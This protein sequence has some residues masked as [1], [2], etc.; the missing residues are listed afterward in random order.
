MEQGE[1]PEDDAA[2]SREREAAQRFGDR[3]R[4]RRKELGIRQEDVAMAAGVSRRFVIDLEAG[5][6][7]CYLGHALL[8]MSELGI[9]LAH[10]GDA[11]MDLPEMDDDDGH[12][13]GIF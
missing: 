1:F 10:T 11:A 6:P 12:T 4:R 5:K 3:I 2:N 9:E 7:K 13:P 8:V